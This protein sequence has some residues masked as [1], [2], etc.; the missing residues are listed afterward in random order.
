MSL[1]VLERLMIEKIWIQGRGKESAEE[2]PKIIVALSNN[3][4]K[5]LFID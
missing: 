2:H 3:T 5:D 1:E 4:K